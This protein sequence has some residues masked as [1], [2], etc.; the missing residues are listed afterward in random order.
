[1]LMKMRVGLGLLRVLLILRVEP[2]FS[3][4]YLGI[5]ELNCIIL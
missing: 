4:G 1:M 5:T 3:W 2:N